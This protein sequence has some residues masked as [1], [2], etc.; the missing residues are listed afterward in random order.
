VDGKGARLESSVFLSEGGFGKLEYAGGCLLQFHLIGVPAHVRAS[1]MCGTES[2]P[3]KDTASM[4]NLS[5][6]SV[7]WFRIV[8]VDE[9]GGHPGSKPRCPHPPRP[10]E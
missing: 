7:E 3:R 9:R 5:N 4:S 8:E 1:G 6:L 2:S 10:E